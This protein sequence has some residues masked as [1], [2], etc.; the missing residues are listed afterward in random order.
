MVA[1]VGILLL[2]KYL[3][4][5][6]GRHR[7]LERAIFVSIIFNIELNSSEFYNISPVQLVVQVVLR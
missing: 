5:F 1:V 4:L 7:F 6:N 3:F 2:I